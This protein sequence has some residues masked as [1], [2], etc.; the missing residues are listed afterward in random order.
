[1]HTRSFLAGLLVGVLLAILALVAVPGLGPP[2]RTAT[3]R[4]PRTNVVILQEEELHL[5][6]APAPGPPAASSRAEERS[7]EAEAT[8]AAAADA[9][10]AVREKVRHASRE[11]AAIATLRNVTSAQAQ[12]QCTARADENQNGI[13]EYGSFAELSGAAGVRDGKVLNPPVLSTAFRL[14]SKGRAERNGY[15]YRIYLPGAGGLPVTER[16]KGGIGAGEVDPQLAETT[17]CVYAWP[18]EAE[19]RAFFTNQAGD[20]LASEPGAYV[21]EREPPPYAAFRDASG[22]TAPTVTELPEDQRIGA[23]RREWKPL[24]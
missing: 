24:R 4:A 2:R 20:V 10:E 15:R 14:V 5:P 12:F 17:W 21:G 6:P 9:D 18:V 1:M 23:D 19:G 11:V 13:G 3:E 22:L 16:D 7:P 8:D